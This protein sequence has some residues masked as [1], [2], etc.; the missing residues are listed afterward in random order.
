M[1]KTPS[2]SEVFHKIKRN[3]SKITAKY[4]AVYE[5]TSHVGQGCWVFFFLHILSIVSAAKNGETSRI[6]EKSPLTFVMRDYTDDSDG[7]WALH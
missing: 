3:M 6:V 5:E 4:P 1:E 7:A 2:T